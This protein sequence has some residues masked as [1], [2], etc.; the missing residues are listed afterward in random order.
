MTS[1]S[2]PPVISMV[3]CAARNGVIGKDNALPWKLKADLRHF[4][5]FTLGKAVL[6]GRTTFAS[7]GDLPLPK[8]EN[9][10]L[11]RSLRAHAGVV[12]VDSFAG[13]VAAAAAAGCAE[14]VVCGGAA[15]YALAQPHASRFAL[16]VVDA[17]IDG[18]TVLPAVDD[19]W[20]VDG[21]VVDIAA[22]ADNTHRHRI[23]D[24]Q[25]AGARRFVWPGV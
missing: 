9:I 22:D 19:N 17:D 21:D 23:Y 6:M 12:V 11:S 3:A 13:A 7:I 25:R 5:A 10:I 2:T 20:F 1:T 14:L 16:T 24:L 4:K 8:R 18:D 15:V